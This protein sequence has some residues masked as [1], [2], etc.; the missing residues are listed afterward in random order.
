MKLTYINSLS[1]ITTGITVKLFWGVAAYIKT[2]V[3]Q[4]R[5]MIP[6][7]MVGEI[8]LVSRPKVILWPGKVLWLC[9]NSSANSPITN[10]EF[11]KNKISFLL[12]VK[13][14]EALKFTRAS[15]LTLKGEES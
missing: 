1:K 14:N 8:T 2:G 9:L 3:H 11:Q 12:V 4:P 5:M 15:C 7:F 10:R 13:N 6:R